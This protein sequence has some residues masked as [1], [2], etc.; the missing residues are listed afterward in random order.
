MSIW[1]RTARVPS[2][3]RRQ[4]S[5]REAMPLLEPNEQPELATPQTI[6][7]QTESADRPIVLVPY[8]C[9]CRRSS[10]HYPD[11]QKTTVPIDKI[12]SAILDR[13]S[14]LSRTL[15]THALERGGQ[16]LL[17][18]DRR[19]SAA[20]ESLSQSF[21]R[22]LFPNADLGRVHAVHRGQLSSRVLALDRGK[23]DLGFEFCW[24]C[25]RP[26]LVPIRLIVSPL[27][28]GVTFRRNF[29]CTR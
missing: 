9:L 5:R 7:R 11:P 18:S 6:L 26:F 20:A 15:L 19:T 22:L 28:G 1:V 25:L 4:L 23:R 3:D 21:Q 27:A 14:V 10:I 2:L 16:I 12:A 24:C 17:R 29:R 13:F 8:T